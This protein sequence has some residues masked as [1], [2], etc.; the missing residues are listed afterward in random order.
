MGGEGGVD[1]LRESGGQEDGE[2]VLFG[3]VGEVGEDGSGEGGVG[4][5]EES[6]GEAQVV[7]DG[8]DDDQG[9]VGD[10]LDELFEFFEGSG[11]G[12]GVGVM[13]WGIRE[14]IFWAMWMW[15]RLA[16][17]AS[18]LGRRVS[19]ALSSGERRRVARGRED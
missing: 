16:L 8:V 4:V 3:E 9:E 5:G 14:W 17:R 15:S 7:G 6:V 12:G 11:G 10:G 19:A 13:F 18:S 2:V 1:S